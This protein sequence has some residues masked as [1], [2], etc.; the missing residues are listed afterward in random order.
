MDRLLALLSDDVVLHADG[1]GKGT[2]VP[3]VVRGPDRIARGVLRSLDKLLPT[4][5][6]QRIAQI[7]GH[8]AVISYL[9]G[10]PHSVL[11][12]DVSHGR[13]RAIYIVTNPD[14]LAHLPPAAG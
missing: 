1:G 11:T 10:Q 8:S 7:N 9:D 13:I 5:L 14:K 12:L 2:A 6:V 3:N 4:N